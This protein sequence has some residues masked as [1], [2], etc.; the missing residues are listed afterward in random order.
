[1]ILLTAI[2]IANKVLHFEA[3]H[4]VNPFSHFF[5]HQ[6]ITHNILNKYVYQHLPPTCFGVC[7]T[8]LREIIALMAQK[9]QAL[10][11]VAI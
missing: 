3:S 8:I 6:Q 10:C 7:Y 5:L 9:P 4:S 2:I 11:S 1:M